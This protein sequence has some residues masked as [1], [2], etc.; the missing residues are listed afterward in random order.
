MKSI[1]G[2]GVFLTALQLS[3]AQAGPD[4][5]Q[6]AEAV[7]AAVEAALQ[8]GPTTSSET[9]G[10]FSGNMGCGVTQGS[11]KMTVLMSANGILRRIDFLVANTRFTTYAI[12]SNG[13]GRAGIFCEDGSVYY[14]PRGG[15]LVQCR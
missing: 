14:S 7:R 4:C 11:G 9:T 3:S 6:Q 8:N 2:L 15:D 5:L 10:S 13:G 1:F 12:S